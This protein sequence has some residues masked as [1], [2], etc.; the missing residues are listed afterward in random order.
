[1][2]S[3]K[4]NGWCVLLVCFVILVH[5][6]LTPYVLMRS[7][8][9]HVMAKF[10]TPEISYWYTWGCMIMVGLVSSDPNRYEPAK[11]SLTVTRVV[12]RLVGLCTTL[13]ISWSLS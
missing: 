1:M 8:E 7:Y 11:D 9:W 10:G 3:K 6:A 12:A 13:L 2:K 4:E 5:T